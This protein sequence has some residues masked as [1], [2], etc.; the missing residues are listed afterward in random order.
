ML[1]KKG[2]IPKITIRSFDIYA[3]FGWKKKLKGKKVRGKNV[4]GMKVGRK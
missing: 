3:L 1:Q 4:G 2:H